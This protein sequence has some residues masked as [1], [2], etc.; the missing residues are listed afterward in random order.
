MIIIRNR[1]PEMLTFKQLKD[2]GNG[3]LIIPFQAIRD[4]DLAK[5]PLI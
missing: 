2:Q 4:F 3:I 1:A 5:L